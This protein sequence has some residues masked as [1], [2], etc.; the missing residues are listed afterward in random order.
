MLFDEQDEL[1]CVEVRHTTIH[2]IHQSRAEVEGTRK[3]P[4]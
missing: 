3:S 4:R 1:W 2:P